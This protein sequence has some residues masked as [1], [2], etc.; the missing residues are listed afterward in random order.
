MT[1]PLGLQWFLHSFTPLGQHFSKQPSVLPTQGEDGGVGRGA[2]GVGR[3]R[4]RRVVLPLGTRR[5]FSSGFTRDLCLLL[6]GLRL[7]AL[8]LGR[9]RRLTLLDV[10]AATAGA[11]AVVRSLHFTGHCG[12]LHEEEKDTQHKKKTSRRVT[13]VTPGY[14]HNIVKCQF[15]FM[16][17]MVASISR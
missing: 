9:Y 10:R 7:L 16:L 17:K 3:E 5:Q 6:F 12:A 1:M 15:G 8:L 2:G 13:L 4:G 14:R 11:G